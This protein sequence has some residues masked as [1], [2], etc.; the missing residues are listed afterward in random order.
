[1]SKKSQKYLK[2]P[3]SKRQK[4][5]NIVELRFKGEEDGILIHE[6][7]LKGYNL[8]KYLAEGGYGTVYQACDM[9][10]KCDYVIKIQK[11][12]FNNE[13]KMDD[14]LREVKMTGILSIEHD[15]GPKFLGAWLCEQD[16]VGIIVS[17]LW[18][19][20]LYDCPP[21]Y[22]IEKLQAQ[23]DKI[24]ELGYVHG[25]ILSKNILVKKDVDGK[26]VDATL[27]D[28]GT[29]ATAKQ[30]KEDEKDYGFITDFYKYH[31]DLVNE[32]REYYLDNQITKKDVI[33]NPLH[34]DKALMY[35]FNKHCK[36]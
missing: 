10:K 27:T 23:I 20:R 35:F 12:D 18:D 17:E 34:F 19:G 3:V 14:W 9:E 5:A 28:F 29:V 25:D 16:E 2:S 32:T 24:N 31:T 11:L 26:I 1:M 36:K 21:R 13:P 7:C 15:I 4:N 30:W 33:K 22:L 6:I 8:E